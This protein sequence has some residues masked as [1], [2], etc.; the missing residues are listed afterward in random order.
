MRGVGTEFQKN[1]GY[2]RQNVGNR[3]LDWAK[4]PP[5]FKR[6]ETSR[7]VSLATPAV[8]GGI[9]LWQ[10]MQDRRSRRNFTETPMS[11]SALSQLLWATQGVTGVAGDTLFRTAPSA[12]GLFPIETYLIVNR[13][14]ELESG[15]HHLFLP[16]WEL[17]FL[18]AGSL[19]PALSSAALGQDMLSKAAVVFAWTAVIPRSA[20]KYEQ[21]AYRYIY[22]DAGHI[23][24][25]LYLACEALGLGCCAVGAF[26]DGEVN[27]ILGVD[28]E[29]ETAIYLAAAG[30]TKT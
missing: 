28:G 7:R 5:T 20:W 9:P 29:A 13:V 21:R 23:C 2:T 22:L 3:G 24:Q 27:Q 6:Y 26:F 15:L 30:E 11:L 17:E 12:G 19:G 10:A 25:N 8:E 16:E 18:S 14:D 4:K 1:T